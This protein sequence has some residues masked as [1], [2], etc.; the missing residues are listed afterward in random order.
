MKEKRYEKERKKEGKK[1][2]R[3]VYMKER[4]RWKEKKYRNKD[5]N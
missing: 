3:I 5:R 4:S 2:R 1:E